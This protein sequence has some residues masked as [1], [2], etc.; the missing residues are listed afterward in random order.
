MVEE[1]A[2][3]LVI[4]DLLHQVQEF[5]ALASLARLL[6]DQLVGS[7][8]HPFFVQLDHQPLVRDSQLRPHLVFRPSRR[9]PTVSHPLTA[10]WQLHTPSV[11][12]TSGSIVTAAL[13]PSLSASFGVEVGDA[14]GMFEWVELSGAHLR[15]MLVHSILGVRR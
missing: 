4:Q 14:P 12:T 6:L 1:A 10:S 9:S 7:L 11:A 3:S 8:A 15:D 13:H 5:V 2:G